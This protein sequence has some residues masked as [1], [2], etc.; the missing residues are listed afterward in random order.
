MLAK[1]YIVK[2][3]FPVVSSMTSG[4]PAEGWHW[5]HWA[6]PKVGSLVGFGPTPYRILPRS[7]DAES[8]YCCFFGGAGTPYLEASY[9]ELNWQTSPD[10]SYAAIASPQIS[11]IWRGVYFLKTS[12]P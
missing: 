7:S 8:V 1:Q 2:V 3:S 6:W 4:M 10:A 11:K 5:K 12:L 9:F